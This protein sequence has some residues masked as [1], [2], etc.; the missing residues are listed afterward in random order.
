MTEETHVKINF[1]VSPH[2]C[3]LCEAPLR[4]GEL[5]GAG[6]NVG[7]VLECETCKTRFYA[8]YQLVEFCTIQE[9]G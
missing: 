3:P 6:K 8:A 7:L 4:R 1:V 2:E 5:E 9:G